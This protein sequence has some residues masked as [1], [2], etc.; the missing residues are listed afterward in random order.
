MQSLEEKVPL[1]AA[2]TENMWDDKSK[3]LLEGETP[4][5]TMVTS[6]RRISWWTFETRNAYSVINNYIPAEEVVPPNSVTLSTQGTFEFLPHAIEL[7]R[8]WD[9]HISIAIYAPGGDFNVALQTI[10]YFRR[11]RDECF[12]NRIS[13]HFIYDS[14][15]GPSQ[16]EISFPDS[17]I[18]MDNLALNCSLSNEQLLWSS[19]FRSEHKLPY[20]INVARNVARLNSQTK[21]LLAS[22]I[23]LYPSLHVSALFQD[24]LKREANG[25]VDLVDPRVPHV[26]VFP[27]F[28]V[29]E[30]LEAPKT[31]SQLI[32]MIKK[33]NFRFFN[34]NFWNFLENSNFNT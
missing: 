9:G 7:C 11:C 32:E 2:P 33:G 12:K 25:Q 16:E 5:E 23:E 15:H 10:Y 14:K 26:Y 34:S 20:P 4:T 31:K 28:E 27:I 18:S 19:S 8:R 1:T 13:W 29:R 6:S 21:Y 30:G 17:L 24:L 22:D 3:L